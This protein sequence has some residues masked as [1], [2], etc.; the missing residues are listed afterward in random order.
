MLLGICSLTGAAVGQPLPGD[1][2]GDGLVNLRDLTSLERYLAPGWSQVIYLENA[3]VNGD[4]AVNDSDIRD[5]RLWLVGDWAP[6]AASGLP[7]DLSAYTL[8]DSER[9]AAGVD[10]LR[11]RY[12]VSCLG[13]DLVCLCLTAGE[14]ERTVLLN[15]EIHGFEDAYDRDGQLLVDL[16]ESVAEHFSAQPELLSG[17]RLLLIPS[18]NPDGLAEGTTNQGFGRCNAQGIDL[19]RDFDASHVV[20][21]D[22]R[23]ATPAPFS[24]VE[25]RAMRD[26]VLSCSPDVVMDMHGWEN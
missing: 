6:A 14:W 10:V 16:A 1:V 26:L 5:L 17:C 7:E 11:F 9:T 22:S 12:G 23:N 18:A 24:A 21:T 8:L 13:R 15:F 2:N 3:D 25:S 20:Y 19:N 4:R